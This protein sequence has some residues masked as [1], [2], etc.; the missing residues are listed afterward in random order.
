MVG[1]GGGWLRVCGDMSF[2]QRRQ[3]ASGQRRKEFW[4]AAAGFWAA[5][6]GRFGQR[7]EEFWAAG[8]SSTAG[9]RQRWLAGG[10]LGG[11]GGGC[12]AAL[13]VAGWLA[14]LGSSW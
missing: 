7:R 13:E 6:G 9:G 8:F 10:L 5:A 2:G 14:S 3:L 1:N 11:G 4:A 12:S